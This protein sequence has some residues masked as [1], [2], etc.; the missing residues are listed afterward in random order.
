MSLDD[1]DF[2]YWF[3]YFQR[4]KPSL[5]EFIVAINTKDTYFLNN[6]TLASFDDVLYEYLFDGGFIEGDF[7]KIINAHEETDVSYYEARIAIA[8]FKGIN[9]KN[10]KERL[11]TKDRPD[12]FEQVIER[13]VQGISYVPY[14]IEFPKLMTSMFNNKSIENM[15]AMLEWGFMHGVSLAENYGEKFQDN[16]ELLDKKERNSKEVEM[17]QKNGL[18]EPENPKQLGQTLEIDDLEDDEE[19]DSD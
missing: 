11:N 5:A 4:Y 19:F 6:S 14:G 7:R 18:P 17:F 8:I 15:N 16:K 2:A 10:I 9:L 12:I 13:V 1:K 3:D